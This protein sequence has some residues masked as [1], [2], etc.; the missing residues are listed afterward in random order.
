ERAVER[1]GELPR[2]CVILGGEA[3]APSYEELQD[4]IGRLVH[5]ERD[6]ETFVLPSPL[7]K[8]GAWLQEK[9]E[10][11]VPDAFDHG[12][13]PFIRPFMIDLAADHYAL[14]CTRA[15][16]LLGWR[17]RHGILDVLPAMIARLKRDPRAW[18]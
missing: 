4:T 9:A 2:E 14:D 8:A 11:V 5:G 10:P 1:R 16:R 15:R 13:K 18:Y 7:A 3:E 6:W 12:E 17:A